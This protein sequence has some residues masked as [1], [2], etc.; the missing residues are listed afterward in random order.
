[1]RIYG[2]DQL[3]EN[4]ELFNVG[5]EEGDG[6]A[7]YSGADMAGYGNLYQHNFIHH[8]MRTPNKK[9]G[10]SAI[11]LDDHQAGATCIGNVFY[12]TCDIGLYMNAG[13]GTTAIGNLF[14]QTKYGAFIRGD[15][16]RKAHR[17][18]TAIE[19]N[20]QHDYVGM[21]EDYVGRVENEIGEKA[22]FKEPWAS[23]Y[24][25]FKKVMSEEGKFGRAWPIYCTAKDNMYFGNVNDSTHLRN[26]AKEV[27]EKTT[28]INDIQVDPSYFKDYDNLDFTFVKAPDGVDIIPFEEIGLY[29][30]QYRKEMPNKHHYR[31]TIKQYFDGMPAY[32]ETFKLI[33]T[34]VLVEECVDT[35]PTATSDL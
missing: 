26:F 16:G 22:W 17:I 23:K 35:A 10:R 34:S 15:W 12:K 24:P 13:A 30:D 4:N 5:Y 28:L 1:M 8:L 6:G 32:E 29:L 20:P 21:K 14:L 25:L 33:N 18:I 7:L 11:Y 27:R 3:I 31:S 19:K 9:Y 2:N